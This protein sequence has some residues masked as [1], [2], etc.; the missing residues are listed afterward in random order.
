M[1]ICLSLHFFFFSEMI[2][3][4]FGTALD[5]GNGNQVTKRTGE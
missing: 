4:E 1:Q 3:K 2:H 5:S